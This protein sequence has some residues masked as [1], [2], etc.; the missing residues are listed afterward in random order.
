MFSYLLI[1]YPLL[2]KVW[3]ILLYQILSGSNIAKKREL[4]KA[5]IEEDYETKQL[6]HQQYYPETAAKLLGHIDSFIG[7][8]DELSAKTYGM[9]IYEHP[10]LPLIL[11]HNDFVRNVFLA[12]RAQY[13][14]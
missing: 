4:Y 9:D 10:R 2:I 5:H 7:Q 11:A 12:V 13:F 14:G 1:L 6:L 3:D 8:L